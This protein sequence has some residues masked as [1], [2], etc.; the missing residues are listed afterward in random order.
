MKENRFFAVSNKGLVRLP[1]LTEALEVVKAG[2][3]GYAW[4]DFF[5]APR[6]D[7]EPLIEHLG[8]HPLSVED[9]VNEDQ[10][11]KIDDLPTNTFILINACRYADGEL[12]TE[13]VDF[14]IGKGF[15]ISVHRNEQDQRVITP[16]I[17]ELIS[18]D[19]ANVK[20]GPEFLL[21]VLVDYIV[22]RKF[23]AIESLNED[24]ESVEE[25]ILKDPVRFNPERLLHLRRNLLLLRKS[26]FHEREVFV[27]ICRRDSPFIGDKAIYNFRDIYDHLARFFETSE[28]SREMIASHMEMYLSL[29]NNRMNVV[30]NQTNRVMRRLT[31]ITTIFMP[32]TLLAG[33]GGMSEWSMMTGP[34]HWKFT[35]PLFLFLMLV[36]ASGNWALLRWVDRR[37][38]TKDR[39]I[40]NDDK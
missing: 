12:T 15:V 34:E 36:I 22:D 4:L 6:E 17:E 38:S 39:A 21:H 1:G 8:L 30:A 23:A 31:F 20:K 28:I 3:A 19:L 11:P 18:L 13:E 27:R 2:G 5:N 24:L 7:L 35:Y 26:L 29:V 32:L 10:I 33:I 16:R 9:C 14:F 37:A 40:D 25:D